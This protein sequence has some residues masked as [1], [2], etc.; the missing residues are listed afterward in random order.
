MQGRTGEIVG[1]RGRAKIVKIKN[2]KDKLYI[3]NPIHL[4]KL[5]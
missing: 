5:K 2:G 1:S 4:K 3:I